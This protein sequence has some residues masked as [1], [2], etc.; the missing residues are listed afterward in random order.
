[1]QIKAKINI[2][3]MTTMNVVT[4]TNCVMKTHKVQ[5][6]KLSKIQVEILITYP[7]PN[8][9]TNRLQKHS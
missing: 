5:T 4:C 1:L 6:V 9:I 2:V 7:M 3:M 8:E